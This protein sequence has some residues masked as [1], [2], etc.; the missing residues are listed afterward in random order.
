MNCHT[1]IPS[2]NKFMKLRPQQTCLDV[3]LLLLQVQAISL[4]TKM[5]SRG[6]LV[7]SGSLGKTTQ[8][9]VGKSILCKE[10]GACKK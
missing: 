2:I 3:M 8:E 1:Y 5:I 6:V 4:L 7:V 9:P 10:H